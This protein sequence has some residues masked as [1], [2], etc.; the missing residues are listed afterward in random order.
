[1][2]ISDNLKNVIKPETNGKYLS[3]DLQQHEKNEYKT[4]GK[5]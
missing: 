5:Q 1:M 3:K 2:R 4:T